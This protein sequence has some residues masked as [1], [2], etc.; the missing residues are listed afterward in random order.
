MGTRAYSV[1]LVYEFCFSLLRSMASV[2]SLVYYSEVVGLNALQ[3]VLVGTVLETAC[4]VLEIPTGV[5]ADLYSRRRSVITGVFLYGAG[6][7]L[8]GS[9]PW[10][11]AVLL[12]QVVW[13]CGDTFISG[14]LEA[15]IASEER[16]RPMDEVF[17]RGG[18]TGQAGGILGIVLGTLLGGLDLRLPIVTAGLLFLVFGLVLL[19]VMPETNFSPV[20]EKRNNVLADMA[21]LFKVNLRFVKGAPVLLV[22]LAVVFCGGL[23]SEGFD[24]LSTVRF[25]EDVVMPSFGPLDSVTWFGVMRLLGGGLNIAASQLLIAHMEKRGPAGRTGVVFLTSAGYILSLTLFALGKGF[26]LMLAAFLLTGLMRSLKEPLLA[27][28][29]SSRAEEGMRATVFSTSGQLDAFG[30]IIGGPIAGLAAQQI[31]VSFGLVCTAL[32]LLPALFLVPAAGRA[33][34][35]ER[36]R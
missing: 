11:G 4:F 22:L 12:A 30:Q 8:E 26:W 13:G 17:L 31:S 16:E 10:F 25:L 2:L 34:K 15:W 28:W 27:A 23:A 3:L 7:I 5:V 32:L 18:Q 14:A 36:T 24:R 21:G 6:F 9:L 35:A 20:Q 33:G 19:R 29:M 1:Y